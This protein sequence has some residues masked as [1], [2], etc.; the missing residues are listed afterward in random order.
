LASWHEAINHT[1]PIMSNE[2]I[3]RIALN[4]TSGAAEILRRAGEIYSLLRVQQT[5]EASAE[6][7]QQTLIETCIGLVKAQPD[8]S[9]LLRLASLAIA[10]AR[11][12]TSG[13]DA[14]RAAEAASLG[15]IESAER[16][17]RDAAPHA[18]RLIQGGAAI[19][20]H[21]RSSTVL[22]TLIEAARA[23]KAFSVIATESRP[24]LEGRALAEALGN[25]KIRVTLIAD[26]AASLAMDQV[27]F[28]LVGA[29]TITPREI[30]NKI[31]T[32]M[33]ALAARERGLPVYAVCDTSKFI[34]GDYCRGSVRND[35]T[36]DDLWPGKPSGIL[37]M[38]RYF[39]PTPLGYFTGIITEDGALSA[40][41]AARCAEG[42]T[43]DKELVDALESYR[44]P[45]I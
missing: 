32:R 9:P 38:N 18:A 2:A 44:V 6:D 8:M 14:L 4:N 23:G 20:T 42:A 33:I 10:A 22:A 21:S 25:Q 34:C 29:D 27:D 36:A 11:T 30:V 13:H 16:G 39:E 19:L 41:E 5:E 40:E 28:I 43:I 37:T 24:A 3:T 17:V 26:S 15:F 1:S 35:G 12:A 45:I 31:G 7:A